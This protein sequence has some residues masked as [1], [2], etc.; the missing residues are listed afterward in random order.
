[1]VAVAFPP[2]VEL[3]AAAAEAAK[4]LGQPD[5]QESDTAG[6]QLSATE[7]SYELD[8]EVWGPPAVEKSTGD[9]AP[10]LEDP[11]DATVFPGE[12]EQSA[13]PDALDDATIDDSIEDD[14]SAILEATSA[15]HSHGKKETRR[16]QAVDGSRGS[17]EEP[18]QKKESAVYEAMPVSDNPS[19]ERSGVEAVTT[20]VVTQGDDELIREMTSWLSRGEELDQAQ[21]L[22]PDQESGPQQSM[23]MSAEDA[24]NVDVEIDESVMAGIPE[25]GSVATK[26]GTATMMFGESGERA[27]IVPSQDT[28]SLQAMADPHS[29]IVESM[30]NQGEGT[31][32]FFDKIAEQEEGT[33]DTSSRHG[34]D[35]AAMRASDVAG[36]PAASIIESGAHAALGTKE[37]ELQPE[38]S[39]SIDPSALELPE[40]SSGS[41]MH[42]DEAVSGGAA[43]ADE[44][45]E[46]DPLTATAESSSRNSSKSSSQSSR[47][48]SSQSSQ[49]QGTP[50]PAL[51]R[52]ELVDMFPRCFA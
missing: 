10:T 13:S 12:V 11:E 49:R 25:P 36:I 20:G 21:V 27:V 50:A 6:E 41:W 8:Q 37:F 4:V 1:M 51:S 35:S 9:D 7:D 15:Y 3:Q 48:S 28:A 39:S 31:S 23:E 24:S 26:P 17:E 42:H 40:K 30:A 18:S 43:V 34:P 45:P 22:D 19:Q 47:G 46:P 44:M 16:L 5:V 32:K 38:E 52:E 2:T 14:D 33:Q 29:E